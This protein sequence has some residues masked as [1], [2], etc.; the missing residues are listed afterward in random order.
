MKEKV[1]VMKWIYDEALAQQRKQEYDAMVE[2]EN[3]DR[4][5]HNK[6]M[7]KLSYFCGIG[8][9]AFFGI[10]SWM[11]WPHLIVNFVCDEQWLAVCVLFLFAGFFTFLVC[12]LFSENKMGILDESSR[13]WWK[14]PSADVLY[15]EKTEGKNVLSRKINQD[16][17]VYLTLEDEKHFVST[18]YAFS[19]NKE[20]STA[21]EEETADLENSLYLIPYV[22]CP[23]EKENDEINC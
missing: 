9:F 15:F 1:K 21:V 7:T 20:I 3:L 23:E 2:Q 14:C 10:G 5:A 12:W 16:G 17:A 22:S 13:I 6:K 18:A 8:I 19:L 11:L 4:K